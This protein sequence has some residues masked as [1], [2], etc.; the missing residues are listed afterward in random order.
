MVFT[1]HVLGAA[2]LLVTAHANTT[3]PPAVK[4]YCALGRG[5]CQDADGRMYSYLQRTTE[6]PN[7]ETCRKQECEQFGG[8]QSYCGFEYSIT[9][10]CTCVFDADKAPVPPSPTDSEEPEYV[11]KMNQG[12]GPIASTLG[13]PGAHCYF[14]TVSA[15]QSFLVCLCDFS[16]SQVAASA[17]YRGVQWML[18]FA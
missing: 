14:F 12:I 4:G 13:T 11:S 2:L 9:K 16:F 1:C 15:S 17:N 8:L 6:L 7:A 3:G 10:Q 18:G 5:S